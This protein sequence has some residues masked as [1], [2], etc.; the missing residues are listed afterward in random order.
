M[1]PTRNVPAP[2]V[3]VVHVR[4]TVS[5][6]LLYGVRQALAEVQ[7]VR[8][9]SSCLYMESELGRFVVCAVIGQIEV[10]NVEKKEESGDPFRTNK[11]V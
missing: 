1:T 7:V 11:G 3:V 4:V 5:L 9:C 8:T 2:I 6:A 10:E